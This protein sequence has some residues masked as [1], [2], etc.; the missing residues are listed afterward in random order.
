MIEQVRN[1]LI[2]FVGVLVIA[3]LFLAPTAFRDAFKDRGWISKPISLGLDLSGGV[4]LV[5]EVQTKEAVKSRLQSTGNGIRSALRTEKIPVVRVG[6]TDANELELTL[7]NE[8]VEERVKAVITQSFKELS[9][10]EKRPDTGERIKLAYNYSMGQSARIEEESIGQAIETLRNRVDQFGVSEP[11]IQKVGSNRI[12]LQMPGESDIEKVKNLVGK[13]AKLEFRL[14]PSSLSQTNTVTI[15]DQL[16]ASVKVEDQPL[17][18]G[19]SVSDAALSFSE[20]KM[21]VDVKFNSKGAEEFG[22]ITTENVGRQ[23]SIILDG[24]EY[25]RPVIREPIRGGNCQIS[26]SFTKEEAKTLKFVLKSGALPAPLV[27]VEERTVGPT[28]GAESIQKGILSMLVGFAAIVLFMVVYYKKSGALA[29]GTLIVNLVLM[30][31]ALSAFGATLTLPGLAGLAL[32]LGMAVD[33][34]VIIFE[35]I[36]DEIRNGAGRDASVTAGFNKALSAIMDSNVTTLVSA[37]VLLYFGTGPIRGFAVTLTI[38][39]ATT[40]YCATFASRLGF[41]LLE[42]KRGKD[43]SI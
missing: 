21:A 25:S 36:R 20:G 13:V 27:V 40:I 41:D 17:M 16:G 3:L 34:N 12:M 23:L 8:R 24:V 33:S 37:L 11:L 2:V 6:T 28:L 14:A 38:G 32:T 22:R 7:L 31:A 9:F 26:G 10:V 19:D 1:R 35:R 43:L 5:Y 18:T 30:L 15:K 42:L 29:V 4:H 39:I